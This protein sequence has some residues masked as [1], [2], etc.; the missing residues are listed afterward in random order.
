MASPPEER[1]ARDWIADWP[2]LWRRALVSIVTC[3]TRFLLAHAQFE[4]D[5]FT[6]HTAERVFAVGAA[7]Q[8]PAEPTSGGQCA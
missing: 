2:A 1:R 8:S 4:Y 7:V 3:S 5:R 6:P